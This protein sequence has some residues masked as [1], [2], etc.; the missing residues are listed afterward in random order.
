MNRIA[1]AIDQ[2]QADRSTGWAEPS[3][4]GQSRSIR[5]AI[6]DPRLPWR[7][8]SASS[9]RTGCRRGASA[10]GYATEEGPQIWIGAG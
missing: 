6:G 2:A 10:R 9:M 3:A 1:K 5:V 7:G 4:S 8:S